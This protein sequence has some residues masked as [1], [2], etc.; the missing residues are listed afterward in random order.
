MSEEIPEPP[1]MDTFFIMDMMRLKNQEEVRAKKEAKILAMAM[2]QK[3]RTQA[4]KDG[5]A[6][7]SS[8]LHSNGGYMGIPQPTKNEGQKW[9]QG[10]RRQREEKE[11]GKSGISQDNEM[12]ILGLLKEQRQEEK[13]RFG[14]QQI[15][16]E[17]LGCASDEKA[18]Q[19]FER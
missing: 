17:A 15:S 8:S 7:P 10:K 12:F 16:E 6:L 5:R 9:G 11:E 14:G 19:K 18:M 2:E 4:V 13:D 1:K 3:A